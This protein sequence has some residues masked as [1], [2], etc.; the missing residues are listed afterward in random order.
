[1]TQR[2]YSRAARRFRW[3]KRRGSALVEFA[4]VVPVLLALLIGIMEFG[5]LV[6]GNMVISN[7]TREAARN[8]SISVPMAT[9]SSTITARL[10]PMPVT[11][12]FEYSTNNGDSY[13]TV[14]DSNIYN[15]IPPGALINVR[16]R[17][18]H[19]P[20]TGFLKMLK[21]RYIVMEAEFGKE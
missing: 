2:K 9:I 6:Y 15:A 8:A 3:S 21:N 1:M 16:V 4:L 11:T 19:R 17:A 14:T 18:Q 7:V 12:T 5:W 10:R 13:I 20:L